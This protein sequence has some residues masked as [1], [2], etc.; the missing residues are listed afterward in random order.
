MHGLD[1]LSLTV[2]GQSTLSY[3]LVAAPH[4]RTPRSLDGNSTHEPSHHSK[5]SR[6]GGRFTGRST[7]PRMRVFVQKHTSDRLA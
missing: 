2:V 5:V 4:R 1:L 3:K 7:N 6:R